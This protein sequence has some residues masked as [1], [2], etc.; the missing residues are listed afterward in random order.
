MIRE[1]YPTTITS[2]YEQEIKLGCAVPLRFVVYLFLQHGV[3]YSDSHRWAF[4]MFH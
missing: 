3:A 2:G 1:D 4:L